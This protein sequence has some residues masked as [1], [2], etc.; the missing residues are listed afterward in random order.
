MVIVAFL[1]HI[2]VDVKRG[3]HLQ[4]VARLELL[5]ASLTP[6]PLPVYIIIGLYG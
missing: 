3:V 5:F 6:H 2:L 1:S 4:F